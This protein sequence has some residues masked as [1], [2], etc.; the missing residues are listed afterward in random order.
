[1][2]IHLPHAA[3]ILLIGPSNSGKSHFL[4]KL[5]EEGTISSSEIVS[6]DAY[7]ILVGDQDFI[8][9]NGK[10]KRESEL[11]YEKYSALST[12]AFQMMEHVILARAK[13]NRLTFVDATHLQ[14]KE[15]EKYFK[16][17][18]QQH[19]P[20]YGIVFD[21]ALDVL[22]ARDG[23]R[24]KPRG[25][26]RVK[27]QFRK[28][29][30]EKRFIKKEPFTRV[31]TVKDEPI[32]IIRHSSPLNIEIGNG[33]DIIG[34]IHGCYDEMM[35]LIQELGYLE[36][37]G[38]YIHPEG[39]RLMSVGDIMSRGPKSLET[40]EF[41][42]KQI[43]AGLSFMTDSNHG[44]KIGRWL[45][46]RS[47]QLAHG[48]E[49]VQQEFLQYEQ[50]HGAE[51]TNDLKLRLSKMLYNAPSHYILMEN[52]IGKVVVTHAGIRDRYIGK[53]SSRIKDFCRYGD[54]V[55]VNE[56]GKPIRADWFLEH[57]TSEL[58]VWGHD[59]KINPYKINNTINIDQGVVFGGELTSFRYPE[60]AF[61]AIK[62]HANYAGIDGNPLVEAEAKRFN[63]P[64]IQSFLNGFDV[65]TMHSGKIHIGEGN[66]KAAL[67]TISHYT[68]PLE[69]LIYIPPTMSPTPQT[70]SL[71]DYLEHPAEAISY[72]KKHGISK[73][74]AE[75][76]HMGSRAVLLLFKNEKV[77]QSMIDKETLGIISTRTGRAFFEQNVQ[78]KIVGQIHEELL[79]KQYFDKM[80][81]DFVLL[82]AEILPW[83]LKAQSLIDEQYA[84]VAEHAMMDRQ[85]ILQKLQETK[86]LDVSHWLAEY[87]ELVRN[88]VR[89]DAVYQN[90][91]WPVDDL[92]AIKIAPF[93][94][95]AHSDETCF[96]KPHTWH[97]EM[98]RLF[99]QHSKLFI[100]TEYKLIETEQDVASVISWWEEMTAVGH[101]GIVIKPLEFIPKNKG[102]LVQPAIKVRGRE[103]LRIIYGMDYTD[104]EQLA[105]LKKRNPSKKMKHALQEFS[106]GLEGIERFVRGESTARIHE[107]V[108]AILA[109]E[110]DAVDP[111]L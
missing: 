70:S 17:A 7:R 36:V 92:S 47:V 35:E 87:E 110:S 111:R 80:N 102:K 85:K 23:S 11:L 43:E 10:S 108:L 99:A 9:F 68:L 50:M 81:T 67:D 79:T 66:A 59:P 33:I 1:M 107:C 19:V 75:K 49:L 96:H 24:D 27:Q 22:V 104:T 18:K 74:I 72:Y 51:T 106:L 53:T 44:W 88:A 77:A 98:N 45:E 56:N 25:V 48:D 15:R 94:V 21:I 6:S 71:N 41:W 40:M 58:I 89:F 16:I 46:G 26:N 13:L 31:Y 2:Q 5:V 12:E 83:N 82:D 84:H 60:Q 64:N 57:K 29:Q 91:C 38:L 37:E 42:L 95:L 30:D 90:Y 55:E 105:Q 69:Q 109:L 32:Q 52:G 34:D 103:Y 78:Q 14:A 8:D 28:L 4:Q 62:A 76:K 61:V 100:E 54:I 86:N 39:R 3:I 93:H 97:M 20:V 63:P 101:E 65:E 73:L